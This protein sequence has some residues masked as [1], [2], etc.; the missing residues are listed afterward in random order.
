LRPI[1]RESGVRARQSRTA[2]TPNESSDDDRVYQFPAAKRT[3]ASTAY[4]FMKE[5]YMFSD[6]TRIAD[7]INNPKFRS[8]E[9]V[10]LAEGPHKFVHGV[11]LH[12]KDDVEW[13]AIRETNGAVSS[14]PVEW[15]EHYP[16]A[17][18]PV[19]TSLASK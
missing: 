16:M 18:S 6:P 1:A 15:I 8:G 9:A 12:L 10:V 4:C 2:D 19:V 11:F 7:A 14:H 13:A 17:A 5:L 3:L